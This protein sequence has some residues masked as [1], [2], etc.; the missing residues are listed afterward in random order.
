MLAPGGMLVFGVQ[1]TFSTPNIASLIS[2][3]RMILRIRSR[4]RSLLGNAQAD[5]QMHC[6]PERAVRRALGSARVVD[7]RFTNTAE[8]D[9]NGRLAYSD[10]APASGFVGKQ[11]CVVK[12]A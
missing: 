6:L 2:R 7:V 5:M 12:Q 4:I 11:Y 10:Q 8:K 1:D 9:F 3:A